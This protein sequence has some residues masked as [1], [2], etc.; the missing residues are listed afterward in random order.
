GTLNG[1]QEVE[2]ALDPLREPC[3]DD[4]LVARRQDQEVQVDLQRVAVVARGQLEVDA[5][6]K[7]VHLALALQD[8]LTERAPTPGGAK[9]REGRS[10]VEQTERFAGEMRVR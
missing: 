9:L 2:H 7:D 3:L 5:V 10:G 8:A 4:D 1:Q 6:W